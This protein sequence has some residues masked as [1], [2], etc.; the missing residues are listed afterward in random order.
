MIVAVDQPEAKRLL[1]DLKMKTSKGS[2]S[3]STACLYYS[4]DRA[5]VK[6][7]ILILNG[8][9]KGMVNNMFFATN[10]AP[11]YGPDGKVLVSVSL[12]GSCYEEWSDEDL[13]AEVKKE[14]EGWFGEEVREWRHLRSYRIGFAQP[15]QTPP[16]ELVGRDPRVGGGVYVCGDHWASATFDGALVSGKEAAK[17]LIFDKARL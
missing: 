15:D 3:R 13:A 8:S 14:M 16:T 10:V 5:C 11:S 1:P 6:D 17:A 9:G 4:A 12:I 7:P 2:G